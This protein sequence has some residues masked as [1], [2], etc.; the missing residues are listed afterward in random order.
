ML[1]V[2]NAAGVVWTL[3]E[4]FQT[5]AAVSFEG[6]LQRFDLLSL[7]GASPEETPQL[8]RQTSSARLDF[9][10]VPLTG[11]NPA[12]LRSRLQVPGALGRNGDVIHVQLASAGRLLFGAYDNFHPDCVTAFDPV[13]QKLLD[14]LVETRVLRGYTAPQ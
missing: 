11:G 1:D 7:P 10:V 4:E 2:R 8:R 3:C 13:T 14:R 6:S 12:A 9:V 5:D